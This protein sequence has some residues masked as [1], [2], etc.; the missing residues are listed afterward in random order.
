M[1]VDH[2]AGTEIFVD[3]R[4]VIPPTKLGFTTV[5]T[6]TQDCAR[7]RRHRSG[8]HDLVARSTGRPSP[9]FGRGQFQGVTRDHY[10][11]VDLGD[12][13]PEERA[14]VSDRARFDSRYRV[15]GERRH[16]PRQR[17]RAHGLSVEVP[18]GRGGWVTAQDNLG[19]PAGRK[20][21]ILFN[22]T[23]VFRPGTPRK[24]GCA[25]T[26]KSI[27]THP[28]GRKARRMRR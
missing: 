2:P 18:D 16:H 23:N 8:R 24:F 13:A 9:R 26:W 22:L 25:P 15:V 12:D 6:P 1:T 10:L 20:K 7:H 4:F 3:E 27:G 14:A 11:E 19:F 5:T 17:W 28:H 21:T